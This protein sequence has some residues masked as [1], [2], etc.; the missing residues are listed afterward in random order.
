MNSDKQAPWYLSMQGVIASF[1]IV[2]IGTSLLFR[3]QNNVVLQSYHNYPLYLAYLI[4]GIPLIF[5]LLKKAWNKEF[6]SDLLAGISIIVSL[7]LGEYL[8]GVFVILMLSGGEALEV[9]AMRKASSVLDAL[10]KRMPHFTY[11]RRDNRATKVELSEVKI[12]DIIELRPYDICP[13]DGEVI[14]GHGS[15]D[16]SFLTGEPYQV[17]KAPGSAVISGTLNG[18][19]LLVVR[20]TALPIDSRYQKIAKVIEIQASKQVPLRRLG[21]TLGTWYTPIALIIAGIAWYVSNDPT[22]FLSVLIVATP[23][24]LLIAIP[25]AIIGSIS[26]AASRG[27]IIKNPAVLE[28][29]PTCRAM[30]MDKTGT[31]TYGKPL[32]TQITCL[33]TDQDEDTILAKVAA[34]E[35]YSKH[36]LAQAIIN[37]AQKRSLALPFLD[38]VSEKPGQGLVGTFK[39]KIL[40][41]TSRSKIGST[42]VMPP[43]KDGLECIIVEDDVPIAIFSFLDIPRAESKAFVD[44]VGIHHSIH[45]VSI[46]SGDKTK[47]VAHLAAIVGITKFE[48]DLSPEDKL[49]K[50]QNETKLQ[51][52][53]YI[54]DGIND[55]PAL[56]AATVGIA[57][58]TNSD[59][60]SEAADAVV[61]E[62]SLEKVDEL[63]HISKRMKKIALQ[64]AIGGMGL[65]VIGMI[66]AAFGLLTPLAGAITQ[67]VIDILAVLNG[68]RTA[69]PQ[70]EI[71]HVLKISS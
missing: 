47:E 70:K 68:L 54:G 23:C 64:S 69:F 52:T 12:A 62:P 71:R 43:R 59:I 49:L 19:S 63:I 40:K 15:M 55:A 61:L 32:L 7:L 36:P 60:T 67:E 24:P 4:G 5:E 34:L 17:L 42:K 44:H 26:L 48:G 39:S 31:L 25:I 41:V 27:I 18:E 35:T 16:E 11:V 2:S 66:L 30:I 14:E 10:S 22:R 50:I 56:Q 9:Y 28:Y 3:F 21:D 8:A 6:G 53:V 1:A 45:S 46:L 65:S 57:I 13:V 33:V 51:K 58:G 29:L 37:E 20:A 38:T